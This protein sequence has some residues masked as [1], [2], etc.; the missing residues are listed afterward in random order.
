[1]DVYKSST[2][3]HLEIVET[4]RRRRWSEDEKLRIKTESLSAPRLMS[5]TATARR[6]GISR[7][8]LGNW[9]RAFRAERLIPSMEPA[10]MPAVIAPR[11]VSVADDGDAAIVVE[12]PGGGRLRISASAPPA[13][14]A[15]VLKALR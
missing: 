3:E 2:F 11:P 1:M 6:H 7:S 9:R 12:L 4:D 15:A 14:A 13:L 5:A 8:Q 10:F